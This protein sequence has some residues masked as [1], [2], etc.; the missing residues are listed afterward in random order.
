MKFWGL[1]VWQWIGVAVTKE[2]FC[3]PA[4]SFIYRGGDIVF[5]TVARVIKQ[6][7]LCMNLG[8]GHF[9]GKAWTVQLVVHDP[10]EKV[11]FQGLGANLKQFGDTQ[12]LMLMLLWM[13]SDLSV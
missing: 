12:V 13:S 8:H 6:S 11:V 3:S 7:W 5:S 2:Q 9:S 4:Y 1:L 10:W